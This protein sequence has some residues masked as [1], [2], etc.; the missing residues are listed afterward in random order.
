[1]LKHT[2]FSFDKGK[3]RYGRVAD[4]HDF[5]ADPDPSIHFYV[6]PDPDSAPHHSDANLQ[7]LVSKSAKAPF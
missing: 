5:K 1:M 3:S 6:D 2:T 7:P 4:P